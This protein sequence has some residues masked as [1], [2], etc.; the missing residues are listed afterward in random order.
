[1]QNETARARQTVEKLSVGAVVGM[2]GS[3]QAASRQTIEKL[4][5]GAKRWGFRWHGRLEASSI[6]ETK[7]AGRAHRGDPGT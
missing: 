1:M 7:R 4:S 2:E 3:K 5:V 6:G